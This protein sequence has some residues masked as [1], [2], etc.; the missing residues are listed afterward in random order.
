MSLILFCL[1]QFKNTVGSRAVKVGEIY[2]NVNW[3]KE[4]MLLA[5]DLLLNSHSTSSTTRRWEMSN[6]YC[7]IILNYNDKFGLIRTHFM[8]LETVKNGAAP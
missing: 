8:F 6:F 2:K 1:S 3:K 5:K 4:E 7:A